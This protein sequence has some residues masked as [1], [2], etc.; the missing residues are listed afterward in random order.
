MFCPA[1]LSKPAYKVFVAL[2]GFKAILE[3]T[4][5]APVLRHYFIMSVVGNYQHGQ[6][7]AEAEQ[8]NYFV[9][10]SYDSR[11]AHK[12]VPALKKRYPATVAT[13]GSVDDIMHVLREKKSRGLMHPEMIMAL[14]YGRIFRHMP[15]AKQAAFVEIK[16][17]YAAH[18]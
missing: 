9:S 18:S 16:I 7:V 14:I 10:V 4:K 5:H 2:R 8:P 17:A 1:R 6:Q 12:P 11:R 3:L 13:I 15:L